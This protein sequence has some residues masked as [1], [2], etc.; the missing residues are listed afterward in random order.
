MKMIAENLNRFEKENVWVKLFQMK[1]NDVIIKDSNPIFRQKIN[2]MFGDQIAFDEDPEYYIFINSILSSEL[3]PH[4]CRQEINNEIQFVYYIIE[5]MSLKDYY[6]MQF[7]DIMDNFLLD[8]LERVEILVD[9]NKE[10]DEIRM[11]CSIYQVGEVI[12]G[13]C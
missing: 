6:I 8:W 2:L 1:N 13:G 9:L 4:N 10:I 5:Y 12:R 7:N 3:I 11:K